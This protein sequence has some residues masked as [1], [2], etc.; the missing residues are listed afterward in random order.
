[1]SRRGVV[2]CDATLASS[3]VAFVGLW[4]PLSRR[5]TVGVQELREGAETVEGVSGG[6]RLA[7]FWWVGGEG[8]GREM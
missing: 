2:G 4:L 8:V 7:V 6:R 1:M 5:E 3:E